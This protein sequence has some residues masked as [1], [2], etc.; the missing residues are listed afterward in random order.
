MN[1]KCSWNIS[2]FDDFQTI[3]NWTTLYLRPIRQ[4]YKLD[5]SYNLSD[6]LCNGST[7]L[8]RQSMELYFKE[9]SKPQQNAMN[10][11]NN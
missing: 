1:S 2:N 7:C 6:Q 10:M 4:Q 3:F 5:S 8:K 9:Q 11:K